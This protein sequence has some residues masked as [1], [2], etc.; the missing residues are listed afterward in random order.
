MVSGT[1][2]IFALAALSTLAL[3]PAAH[4][5]VRS[6][7]TT[8]PDVFVN[9]Q[10]KITDTRITLDRHSANRGDE[11]RFIIRNLGKKPHTFTLGSTRRT[12]VAQSGFS[13]LLRPGQQQILI[14]FLDYR[15][16][17]QYRSTLPHDR[18]LAGM[19][20]VFHVL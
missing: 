12:G 18:E 3:V 6:P 1:A 14:L 10:V 8:T 4:G 19:R 16:P 9:I 20:G 15:G 5:T 7:K 2:R 11:G 13:R 17:L